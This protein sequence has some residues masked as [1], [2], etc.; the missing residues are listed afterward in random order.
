[1]QNR[2]ETKGYRLPEEIKEGGE[3]N[4]GKKIKKGKIEKKKFIIYFLKL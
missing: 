3:E 4:K 2:H 1:L